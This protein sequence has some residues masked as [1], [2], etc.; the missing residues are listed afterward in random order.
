MEG[1]ATTHTTDE[2]ANV[3]IFHLRACACLPIRIPGL[4]VRGTRHLVL[5]N[6]RLPVHSNTCTCLPTVNI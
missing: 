2:R 6:C 5:V 3:R 4:V 1:K